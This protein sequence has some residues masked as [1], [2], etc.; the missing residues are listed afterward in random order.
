MEEPLI[1][2]YMKN[3][4]KENLFK[5]FAEILIGFLNIKKVLYDQSV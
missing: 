1:T 4:E 5:G 3:K 2:D